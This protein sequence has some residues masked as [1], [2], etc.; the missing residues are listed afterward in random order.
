MAALLMLP[1]LGWL[2]FAALLTWQIHML[3]R[4]GGVAPQGGDAQIAL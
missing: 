2:I 4:D 1:Y 3:N